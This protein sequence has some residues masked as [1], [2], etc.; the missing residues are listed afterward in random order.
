MSLSDLSPVR[1]GAPRILKAETIQKKNGTS[2]TLIYVN[3]ILN[4]AS[5]RQFLTNGE[6]PIVIMK[7]GSNTLYGFKLESISNP[8]N[9]G[10]EGYAYKIT[11]QVCISRTECGVPLIIGSGDS[12]SFN[13]KY[14]DLKEHNP[15]YVIF[16][17]LALP[18]TDVNGD[19]Y[20]RASGNG[21]KATKISWAENI[22]GVPSDFSD[23][24]SRGK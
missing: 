15:N 2:E 10:S 11:G 23:C 22:T 5:I 1:F 12:L 20:I 6:F 4:D 14:D 3:N 17:G 21:T 16:D 7:P 24:S 19:L 18:N 9:V 13:V 8:I